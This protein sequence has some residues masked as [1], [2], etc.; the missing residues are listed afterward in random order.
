MAESFTIN[1]DRS[2]DEF[3]EAVAALYDK[4]KYLTI[5]VKLGKPRTS[6]QRKGIEV[7]CKAMSDG[8]N[9][10]GYDYTG[11]LA[12]IERNGVAVPWSQER[13]KSA[14]RMVQAA[15]FPDTVIKGEAKTHKLNADEVTEVYEVVNRKFGE[16]WGVSMQF[17]ERGQF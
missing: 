3:L 9:D 6:N 1:S 7:Y 5:E 4:K 2:R 10:A 16:V 8:L 11:F 17:P 13:F 12:Y 15:M 14:W